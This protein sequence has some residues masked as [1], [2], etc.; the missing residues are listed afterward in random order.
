MMT[1]KQKKERNEIIALGADFVA[2]A[3]VNALLSLPTY[4]KVICFT[5]LYLAAGHGIL[6]NAFGNILRGQVFDEKFLMAIA[7]VGALVIGEYP[8]AVF[9]VL[10]FRTGELFEKLSAITGS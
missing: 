1:K 3:A 5:A 8:E 4:A 9:V 6:Q 10:F 2:L 7:T